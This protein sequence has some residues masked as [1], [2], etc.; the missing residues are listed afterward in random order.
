MSGGEYVY[1]QENIA[2]R[3]YGNSQWVLKV[4]NGSEISE[5]YL[6]ND[7]AAEIIQLIDGTQTLESVVRC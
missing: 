7:S 3:R 4:C 1:W 6:I 5:E 2:L